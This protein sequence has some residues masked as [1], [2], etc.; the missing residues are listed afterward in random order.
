MGTQFELWAP[1]ASQ[2]KAAVTKNASSISFASLQ[3][4]IPIGA[5]LIS[6][7]IETPKQIPQ[8][9]KSLNPSGT[10]SP[11]DNLPPCPFGRAAS[12]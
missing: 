6:A 4:I 1:R 12:H 2:F 7:M 11:A 8:V 3:R 5:S 9:P 10:V